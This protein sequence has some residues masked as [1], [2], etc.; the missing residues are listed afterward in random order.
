MASETW[1]SRPSHFMIIPNTKRHPNNTKTDKLPT[2]W[3]ITGLSRPCLKILKKPLQHYTNTMHK[4]C[5][6]T[7][8]ISVSYSS[9]RAC[10]SINIK[11][12]LIPLVG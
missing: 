1:G 4:I 2:F 12:T 9:D 7:S 5:I 11:L 3:V 8:S 10:I 6:I